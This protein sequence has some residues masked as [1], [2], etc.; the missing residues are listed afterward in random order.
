MRIVRHASARRGQHVTRT[1]H[2]LIRTVIHRRQASPVEIPASKPGLHPRN[3]HAQR[4]DFPALI[5]NSPE[6]AS[7]VRPNPVGSATIDFAD[8]AAVLSLNRALLK[9]H[10]GISSWDIPPGYLCPPIPGRADY[11]HHL[12]DLLAEGNAGIIPRGPSVAVLDI[13]VGAN[14]VY[15]IIGVREY[16]WRFV[17]TEIDPVAAASVRRL[18]AANPGLAGRVECR[19]QHTR[20]KIFQGVV[21]SGETFALSMCNPPFHAS[22]VEAATGTLRK[23]RNLDRA[24]S[25]RGARARPADL[26]QPTL[27]FGGRSNE[28]WC[29]GG[30]SAFVRTMIAESARQPKLC[31]WFTTLVAKRDSLPAIYRALERAR[32]TDVRTIDIAHGQ[33]KTRIVAW[34]F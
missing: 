7:F 8:P 16:D 5:Q 31:G 17:G 11:I 34:R 30:E 24:K 14:C 2:C 18:I 15:P 1:Y 3:R 10:Y 20:G 4:Y 27:N 19:L 9:Y 25:A 23:L 33:K 6:L 26:A 13:G 32:A 29:E 22:P 12:A 28:L 21:Q